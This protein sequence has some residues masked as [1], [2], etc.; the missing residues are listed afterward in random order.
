MALA[1][2]RHQGSLQTDFVLVHTVD[3][4]LGDSEASVG[5]LQREE[6][7]L[8]GVIVGYIV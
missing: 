2:G 6:V 7:A 4:L 5:V 1:D 8:E 3:G